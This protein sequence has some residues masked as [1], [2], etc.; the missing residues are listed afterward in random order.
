ME[1]TRS[2]VA[3]LLRRAGFGPR[4][5][6]LEEAA[7]AGYDATMARL[8]DL[9]G[10]DPGA[11]AIPAPALTPVADL[12][13]ARRSRD[14]KAQRRVGETLRREAIAAVGWW[15]RRMVAADRPL[16][17]K[18]T[19][20]W[21]GHFATGIQK[22]R[23]AALM[24]DQI[25]TFRRLGAGS[26]PALVLAVA[27]DP[28][29]LVWLDGAHNHARQPNENFAR[30]LLE[31]FVLGTG[32]G[33][34]SPYG[35]DDV[36]AAARAFTG[37]GLQGPSAAFVFR[38]RDH[39]AG[40]KTFLGRTGPWD[41][42]D[43]VRIATS[44]PACAPHVVSRLWS[45]FAHPAGPD[46]PVVQ[47]LARHFAAAPEVGALV[48]RMFEHE[49]FLAPASRN[50]LVKQP[51][52]W[53]VGAHRSLGLELDELQATRALRRLGQVPLAPPSVG[54]WPANEAWLTTAAAAARLDLAW[55]LAAR[56]GGRLAGVAPRSRPE[57]AARLLGVDGWG[58]PTA[59]A[60]GRVADDARAVLALALVAPEYLLA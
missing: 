52:E 44:H 3:H 9:D 5:G 2:A 23:S 7:A 57:A 42:D 4:P 31:L 39:D 53:L 18:L 11:D 28:A 41:G 49:A 55:S 36:K 34:A 58:P 43:I 19:W 10:A 38:P 51:V 12:L 1:E 15:L 45:R 21:H 26:F 59:S 35:E 27:R 25:E 17:E 50:G 54:G 37:W 6:E 48:R 56:A 32:H 13:A 20:F 47:E 29:M 24:L 40:M 16:R 14:P 30:E 8:C 46:H 33:G 60:L 22:V